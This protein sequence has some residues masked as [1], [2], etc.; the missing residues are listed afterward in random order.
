[1]LY[2]IVIVPPKNLR[3]KIGQR[4]LSVTRGKPATF[5]VD[6][7]RLIPHLSLFHVRTSKTQLAKLFHVVEQIIKKYEPQ[8][9]CRTVHSTH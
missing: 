8:L 3:H 6:N 1:M 9:Y 2:D 4:V 7:I 5:V